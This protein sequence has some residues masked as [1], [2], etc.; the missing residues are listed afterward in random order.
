MTIEQ[1]TT[2][3]EV[4]ETIV[5]LRQLSA[6]EKIRQEAWYREKQLLDEASALDSAH[7]QGHEEGFEE[8]HDQGFEE[9]FGEGHDQGFTEGVQEGEGRGVLKTLVR[10]VK[11][12]TLTLAQ[13]AKEADMTPSEFEKLMESMP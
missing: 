6:D 13:G 8:G 9:G 3:P 5:Q 11:N 10:L 7:R 4:A 1:T 12:G 2:I